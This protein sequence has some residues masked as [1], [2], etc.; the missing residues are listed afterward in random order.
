MGSP[1]TSIRNLEHYNK[2]SSSSQSDHLHKSAIMSGLEKALFNLKFTAKQLNRQAAKA[3]KDEKTEKDKLKKAIQQG[4]ND[5]AK[6][7]AQ[8][9]IRKQ[10]ERLN[11]L[12]LGSRIDAVASRVQTAV[13]MRQVTG[14]MMN[15]VKGMDQAM[16]AMDLGRRG[17]AFGL[18]WLT[19]VGLHITFLENG[20]SVI[21]VSR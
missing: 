6:I 18:D 11:L 5:I 16:K 13:T 10:N 15:V 12:R 21:Y 20:E 4:H 8:N 9:A 17:M 1:P 19:F 3:S 2:P 7:Y 14:S